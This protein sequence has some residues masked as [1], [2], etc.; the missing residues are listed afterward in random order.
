MDVKK[1]EAPAV[2]GAVSLAHRLHRI[3][4]VGGCIIRDK[5]PNCLVVA[6][7]PHIGYPV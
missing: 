3:A 6:P 2:C 1:G 5:R 4:G 7:S